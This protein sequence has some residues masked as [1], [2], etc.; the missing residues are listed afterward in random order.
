MN[1]WD[2]FLFPYPTPDDPHMGVVISNPGICSNPMIDWVNVLACQTVRP[3]QRLK[4]DN[5]VY[6]DR[7]DGLDWK[8]LI[9]G[10]FVLAFR[11]AMRIE[12]PGEVCPQTTQYP[13][14]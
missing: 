7:A 2:I 5:E 11:K 9:K 1:R 13:W 3:P 10:D 14:F 6:L 8:T 12:K 4:K